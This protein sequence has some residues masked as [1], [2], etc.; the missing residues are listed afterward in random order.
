MRH[1]RRLIVALVSVASWCVAAATG[2]YAM[3]PDPLDGGSYAPPPQPTPTP[4]DTQLWTFVLVAAI[5]AV[6]TVAVMWLVASL[7]HSRAA[8]TRLSQT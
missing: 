4:V 7:R 3:R 6:L 8:A 5:A 1:A 2:A